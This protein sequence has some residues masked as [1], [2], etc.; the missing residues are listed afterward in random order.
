L[1]AI[2]APDGQRTTSAKRVKAEK[3][4]SGPGQLA[5]IGV[6][7][8]EVLH[9]TSVM[10]VRH[11]NVTM[12]AMFSGMKTL[13]EGALISFSSAKRAHET[14]SKEQQTPV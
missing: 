6:L 1:V 7:L 3:N 8:D 9:L 14:Q 11:I 10:Q 13:Q 5:E 12:K 2:D 4:L